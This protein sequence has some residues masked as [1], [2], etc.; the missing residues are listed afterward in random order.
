VEGDAHGEGEGE[1]KTQDVERRTEQTTDNGVVHEALTCAG[2]RM[3]E[4]RRVGLAAAGYIA[5]ALALMRGLFG[6]FT[7]AVPHD[8]GDPLLSTW[9]L[10]WNAHHLPFVGSWWDGL[11][12]YPEHGS[13]AFS[14]HRV[15]LEFISGPVQW[16][17]GGPVLAYN[18]TFVACFVLSALAAYALTWTL[19]RSHIAATVSGVVFGF[20]PYR[21]AHLAHLELQAAFCL[22][23]ALMALHR[24][25]DAP[26]ARW[27]VAFSVLMALQ[28][29]CSGYYLF[30]SIPLIGLWIL[31]FARDAPWRRLAAIAGAWAIAYALLLPVLLQYR[32]IQ[33][34]LGLARTFGEMQDFSAD[35][36]GLLSAEPG[37]LLW[38]VRSL[39]QNPEAEVYIGVIAPLL[40][41]AA[42]RW[43]RPGTKASA[44]WPRLRLTVAAVG[45]VFA[46]AAVS[47]L[48]GSWAVRVGPLVVSAETPGKPLTVVFA[49]AAILT[50]T[51]TGWLA[52]WRRRSTFAFYVVAAIMSWFFSLGPGP[53]V[54]GRQFLYRGPYALLMVLPGFD[55]GFRVPARF[56]M[57]SALALAVAA[58]IAFDRLS[59]VRSR[60]VRL[61]S[62]LAVLTL[63]LADTWTEVPAASTA[64]IVVPPAG[65]QAAAVMELPL[66]DVFTDIEAVYR[67]RF[68]RLPV[69]NGYSG[70]E[71]AA[72][73]ILRLALT[74]QD[75]SIWPMLASRGPL[76]IRVNRDADRGGQWIR[77]VQRTVGVAPAESSDRE[78]FFILPRRDATPVA[79]GSLLTI[80]SVEAMAVPLRLRATADGAMETVWKTA[81]PQRGDEEVVIELDTLQI[82]HEVAIGVGS[83]PLEFPGAVLI[84]TSTDGHEW[85]Q[86]WRSGCAGIAFE[87]VLKDAR[88]PVLRFQLGGVE[89]RYIRV[90]QLWSDPVNRWS[91]SS[92][93][94]RGG[95]SGGGSG[96][97]PVR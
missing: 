87:A 62:A 3:L 7:T 28:G 46:V 86:R 82:V 34:R 68:H 77:Y 37:L 61:A 78:Q 95:L 43:R 20:N 45:T 92:I 58:G 48:W 67:S 41:L 13:L 29:L 79:A 54:L 32:A 91:I 65:I 97:P 81:A 47:T 35:L 30:F 22:P 17:G 74:R 89:S 5:F 70:Y 66:G 51:S 6:Q 94:V 49:A 10:W 59:A 2:V 16:L 84:E 85:V 1:R 75:E 23:L 14:D 27:L 42:I 80:R 52:L 19:T 11:S 21:M 9:I 24:Y 15:G 8:L 39:A 64:A 83:S 40:I 12:F 53:R 33:S 56:I 57:I 63:L 26:R 93:G 72:Y 18:V 4:W 60:T 31:W 76:L 73:R 90:R 55:G 38:R 96:A 71:P 69:V 25:I 50:F 44:R 88:R 36:T